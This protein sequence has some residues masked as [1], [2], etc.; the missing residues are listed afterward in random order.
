MGFF[1][2][3]ISFAISIVFFAILLY[4]RVGLGISLISTAFLM[5]FLSLELHEVVTVLFTTCLDPVTLTLV[6]ATFFVMVLSKLYK[7]TGLVETLSSSLGGFIRNPKVLLSLLP[8][9]IGLMP[10]AGGAVMSAPLVEVEAEKM[11]LDETQKTYINLWFR[12]AIY[13]VYPISQLLILTSILTETPIFSIIY[14]QFFVTIA[15]I[16]V[17]YFLVLRNTPTVELGVSETNLALTA[18]LKGFFFSFFPIIV[19][20]ITALLNLN[21]ALATLVGIFSLIILTKPDVRIFRNFFKDRILWEVTLAAFGALLFRNVTLSSGVSEILGGAVANTNF[22]GSTLLLLIPATLGFLLGS[23]SG[24]IALSVPML[25]ETVTFMPETASLLC[26]SA[27]L[28]YLSA[29][30]HLCLALTAQYF[31]CSLGN[32]YKYLAPSVAATLISALIIYFLV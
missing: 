20:L 27:Y 1:N 31:Q 4:R 10:V 8:A 11:G 28:G 32:V 18:N 21:I 12:H 22:D 26:I 5:S 3:L 19:V 7:E 30:T 6:F 29:P 24:A 14:R 16:A 15:M 17:G 23:F 2:P 9:V 13:P 25:A